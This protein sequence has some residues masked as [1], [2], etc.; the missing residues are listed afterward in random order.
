M[1]DIHT[2][3][4]PNVDDGSDNISLSIEMLKKMYDDGIKEVVLTPHTYSVAQRVSSTKYEKLFNDFEEVVSRE[5]PEI[6]LYLGSEIRYSPT[7]QIN[8]ENLYFKGFSKK[9]VLMEFSMRFEEPIFET[10]Y[11]IKRK[12]YEP[13]LA[14]AERYLY[15]TLEDYYQIKNDNIII[16]VNSGALLGLDGKSL[17]KRAD[18]LMKHDLIDII[19]SDCHNLSNRPPN[20]KEALEKYKKTF[21]NKELI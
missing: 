4:L 20:L 9:Y 3:I 15:L 11:N 14:H 21:T 16:Q 13:I 7:R 6:K 1:I 19:A 17:K 12:G 2:H 8:Y 5:L 10:L 18:L